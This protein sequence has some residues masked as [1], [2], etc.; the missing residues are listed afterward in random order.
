MFSSRKPKI[1]KRHPPPE[2]F[3]LADYHVARAPSAK[4]TADLRRRLSRAAAA[5]GGPSHLGSGEGRVQ[6]NKGPIR[7]FAPE[8]DLSPVEFAQLEELLEEAEHLYRERHYEAE[9]KKQLAVHKTME[10]YRNSVA[11][12]GS[13]VGT[14]LSE[15]GDAATYTTRATVATSAT[16][17]TRYSGYSA[18]SAYSRAGSLASMETDAAILSPVRR[19]VA[20]VV[21]CRR[22]PQITTSGLTG[23]LR[24][25]R[26]DDGGKG[27]I[28]AY[29]A[30]FKE[31]RPLFASPSV[32]ALAK[33]DEATQ[34]ASTGLM[35]TCV[36]AAV[37]V[38]LL[39]QEIPHLR[40]AKR[41]LAVLVRA[42]FAIP[43]AHVALSTGT[44][45]AAAKYQ[46]KTKRRRSLFVASEIAQELMDLRG[47]AAQDNLDTCATEHQQHLGG[48]L[49]QYL[50]FITERDDDNDDA[51]AAPP[52]PAGVP[53]RSPRGKAEDDEV[54]HVEQPELRLMAHIPTWGELRSL[55]ENRRNA[56]LATKFSVDKRLAKLVREKEAV[57][58]FVESLCDKRSVTTLAIVFLRWRTFKHQERRKEHLAGAFKKIMAHGVDVDAPRALFTGWRRVVIADRARV[59]RR[60]MLEV[61]RR[62]RNS[63]EALDSEATLLGGEL[64]ELDR[65]RAAQAEADA[66]LADLEAQQAR[67]ELNVASLDSVTRAFAVALGDCYEGAASL[68]RSAKLDALD[69]REP[70]LSAVFDEKMDGDQGFFDRRRERMS[71]RVADERINS[72]LRRW[73]PGK[74]P[75]KVADA[76]GDDEKL[77]RQRRGGTMQLRRKNKDGGVTVVFTNDE[78][79]LQQRLQVVETGPQP[80]A[81][82]VGRELLAWADATLVRDGCALDD[83]DAAVDGAE[84]VLSAFSDGIKLA[85]LVRRLFADRYELDPLHGGLGEAWRSVAKLA[86]SLASVPPGGQ[87]KER[88]AHCAATLEVLRGGACLAPPIGRYVEVKHLAG[89]RA[90]AAHWSL[91]PVSAAR[92]RNPKKGGAGRDKGS[93]PR[94]VIVRV[95][96]KYLGKRVN[97]DPEA[98]AVG[99]TYALL[100]QLFSTQFYRYGAPPRYVGKH[101]YEPPYAAAILRT[102]PHVL[103]TRAAT[104]AVETDLHAARPALYPEAS[105]VSVPPPKTRGGPRSPEDAL[106]SSA[107]DVV[108]VRARALGRNGVL[109]FEEAAYDQ[110]AGEIVG[111]HGAALAQLEATFGAAAAVGEDRR[112]AAG[113]LH[114]ALRLCWRTLCTTVLAQRVR[115]EEDI[116]DGVFTRPR[117]AQI[118]GDLRRFGYADAE[119]EE[120][121]DL[122][123][124]DEEIAQ[125]CLVFREHLRDMRRIFPF[126]A[127]SGSGSANTMDSTEFWKFVHDCRL[128]DDKRR[129][130]PSSKV[131]LL[132]QQASLDFSKTGNDR[133]EQDTHELDKT[134]FSEVLVRLAC[135]RYPKAI[136]PSNCLFRLLRENV[137]PH[138]C[139]ID[140]DVFRER[141]HGDVV[142]SVQLKHRKN[143]RVVFKL[144]A[145]WDSS[146]PSSTMDADEMVCMLRLAKVIGPL[147]SEMACRTIFAYVQNDDFVI[148][149][150]KKDGCVGGH[151]NRGRSSALLSTHPGS[152]KEMVFTEFEECVAAI[153][154]MLQPDP[155]KMLDQSIDKFIADCFLPALAGH[156]KLRGQIDLPAKDGDKA[157]GSFTLRRGGAPPDGGFTPRT[158]L[159]R[160]RPPR[161][162]PGGF[163]PR[164][165]RKKG[166]DNEAAAAA[167]KMKLPPGA[168]VA[169]KE[170]SKD[171]E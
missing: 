66:E 99:R 11:R 85:K 38:H 13:I 87:D 57:V 67:P 46:R 93:N 64:E 80:F 39:L 23:M 162:P 55:F 48:I 14:A 105:F 70:R 148:E 7:R 32:Y 138:A 17:G 155:Y 154:S 53:P 169:P 42:I 168:N 92:A 28:D 5:G 82:R 78:T 63:R 24:N 84:G 150:L 68:A 153:A 101:P 15:F 83:G 157:S 115:V 106:R 16:F 120:T 62:V 145:S 56:E 158:S 129:L 22:K 60:S 156:P 126:Y 45:T 26:A 110:C 139:Q 69:T 112:A 96:S 59:A 108:V 2:L 20:A 130:L 137:L 117:K 33:L 3:S 90:A 100:A 113:A 167:M 89:A 136:S 25:P 40:H 52:S 8:D 125:I 151:R 30:S 37:T 36:L 102:R 12:H 1:F 97:V 161:D 134:Q 27:P 146:S 127:A 91:V 73:S 159:D 61:Q 54:H 128:Q 152:D 141:L 65:I 133:L 44:T 77:K 98:T 86:S 75:H 170:K 74:E 6:M 103:D 51:A 119:D 94:E 140:A 107:C 147:C 21:Q 29:V 164:L 50:A 116:D 71:D 144:F 35:P 4:V 10:F 76:E 165:D 41:P 122:D 95:V 166:P 121:G 143:L 132:F 135:A 72:D 34:L 111:A 149:D 31:E 142:K 131:D 124:M 43:Q 79:R 19:K 81:F 109:A 9:R 104:D 88:G 58:A 49:A 114:D 47:G 160:D 118:E 123:N 171:G 163:T 18:A